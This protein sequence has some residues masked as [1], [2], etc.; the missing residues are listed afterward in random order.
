M[1][2]FSICW[3]KKGRFFLNNF[4]QNKCS[5]P[6][7]VIFSFADGHTPDNITVDDPR[8]TVLQEYDSW[9]ISGLDIVNYDSVWFNVQYGEFTTPAY[10]FTVNNIASPIKTTI[11]PEFPD[12]EPTTE[13]TTDQ[14]RKRT[15]YEFR[16]KTFFFSNFLFI[17]LFL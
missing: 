10:E 1:L 17:N 16:S 11:Q 2:G 8:L 4:F 3:T 6:E 13:P 9:I 5:F 12:T 14:F 7:A 15:L